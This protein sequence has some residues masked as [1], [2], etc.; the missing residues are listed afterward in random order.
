VMTNELGWS[1]TRRAD[2]IQ[3]L[4]RVYDAAVTRGN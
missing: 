1:V 2:E 3:A 4:A